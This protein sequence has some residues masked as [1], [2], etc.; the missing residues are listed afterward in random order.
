MP[1]KQ[2][3]GCRR[4]V[5]W[6]AGVVVAGISTFL[7]YEASQNQWV[8]QGTWP[9]EHMHFDHPVGNTFGELIQF[10]T[11]RGNEESAIFQKQHDGLDVIASP[12]CDPASPRAVVTTDG[13][14]RSWQINPDDNYS[15]VEVVTKEGGREF[16]YTYMH[17]QNPPD[18]PVALQYLLG[19]PIYAGQPIAKVR[20]A[21]ACGYNHLHYGV[22]ELPPGSGVNEYGTPKNP[23]EKIGLEPDPVPPEILEVHLARRGVAPSEPPWVEFQSLS[24]CTFVKGRVNIIAKILDS[25]DAGSATDASQSVGIYDLKWRAC[26]GGDTDCDWIDTHKYDAMPPE[27]MDP[28]DDSYGERFSFDSPWQTIREEW[29]DVPARL[30]WPSAGLSIVPQ[31]FM[32]LTKGDGWDTTKVMNGPYKLTVKAIDYSKKKMNSSL[33]FAS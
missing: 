15:F 2:P 21:F 16:L 18:A 27:W 33:T 19:E 30:D 24:G 17:L 23:L 8:T 4:V 9:V 10:R 32:I 28:Y 6:L 14:V 3:S 5:G 13:N 20:D 22:A 12:C 25:D 7:L 29:S 1:N 11:R 26:A 31:T